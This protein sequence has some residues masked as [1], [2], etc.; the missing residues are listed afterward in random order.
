MRSAPPPPRGCRSGGQGGLTRGFQ[1]ETDGD[2]VPSPPGWLGG[3]LGGQCPVAHGGL[4]AGF[5]DKLHQAPGSQCWPQS[6]R[7][8][9]IAL[10]SGS[11]GQPAIPPPLQGQHAALPLRQRPARG[12]GC[13]EEVWRGGRAFLGFGALPPPL[14]FQ[15]GPGASPPPGHAVPWPGLLE[16]GHAGNEWRLTLCS[17]RP[18]A[19]S[20]GG[21]CAQL[22]RE[23]HRPSQGTQVWGPF[24]GPKTLGGQ[25]GG[26]RGLLGRPSCGRVPTPEFSRERQ[27]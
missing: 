22:F 18:G 6:R 10:G 17:R 11:S 1:L 19:V 9:A 24:R 23:H 15:A 20:L 7:V 25:Q 12:G 26:G 16:R 5:P 14:L 4:C 27:S 8:G 3:G 2:L 13:G 21:S